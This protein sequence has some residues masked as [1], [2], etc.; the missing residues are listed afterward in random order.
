MATSKVTTAK[1]DNP[2][3]PSRRAIPVIPVVPAI[4]LSYQQRSVNKS[5]P[6]AVVEPAPILNGHH[7]TTDGN[8]IPDEHASEAVSRGTDTPSPAP[9]EQQSVASSAVLTPPTVVSGGHT[10][11]I[12]LLPSPISP[13]LSQMNS[14]LL[15]AS[16]TDAALADANLASLTIGQSKGP[17]NPT[18]DLPPTT[19]QAPELPLPAPQP[20][21][22]NRPAFHQP[23]PSNS[24]LI[25]NPFQQP[26]GSSIPYPNHPAAFIQYYQQ[27]SYLP[28]PLGPVP[29]PYDSWTPSMSH[30][31]PTPHSFQGSQS[32]VPMEEQQAYQ[33]FNGHNGYTAEGHPPPGLDVPFIPEPSYADWLREVAHDMSFHDCE[34]EVQFTPSPEFCDHPA[35]AQ[36]TFSRMFPGHRVIF[37]RSP[38]L[39]DAIIRANGVVR[40]GKIADEYV[41]PDVFRHAL[42]TL[43]AYELDHMPF[44]TNL[45]YRDP[46]DEFKTALSYIATAHYLRLNRI[47]MQAAHRAALLLDWG[48]IEAAVRFVALNEAYS[49]P[50][51]D[52]GVL[53]IT[54][55][56]VE[57]L[58]QN[59]PVNFTIDISPGD[60]GFRRLPLSTMPPLL[61]SFKT[62]STPSIVNGSSPEAHSRQPFN[63]QVQM[64]REMRVTSNHRLSQISF[65]EIT[66]SDIAPPSPSLFPNTGF[67]QTRPISCPKTHIMSKILLH[68]PFNLLKAVLEHPLLAQPAG[69]YKPL[70][71]YAMVTMV[72]DA[73][74]AMRKYVVDPANTDFR[75]YQ[76]ALESAT[77]DMVIRTRDDF[78]VN[79]MGFKEEVFSG[80]IPFLIRRWSKNPTDGV[81]A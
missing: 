23:Q 39:R 53:Y 74:E 28:A 72:I 1:P 4:P 65:G 36:Q 32:S 58:G 59:F 21:M 44:P 76:D 75:K 55:A 20:V 30:G 5:T 26:N 8:P 6:S 70:A 29:T 33:R 50:S 45:P 69:G 37:S 51:S 15:D 60:F 24:S 64:P 12:A 61:P 41:R 9:G 57:W 62:I 10:R 11:G 13:I 35:Y 42:G 63:S 80:D 54:K 66:P 67:S 34:I 31:P 47:A 7:D 38:A 56:V 46:R 14:Q 68:L 22:V 2:S 19:G 49:T 3:N 71:R 43:Y 77:K 18:P 40:L 25:S 52:P 17:M 81:N 78:W 16:L 48:T 73:R 27:H 79:T